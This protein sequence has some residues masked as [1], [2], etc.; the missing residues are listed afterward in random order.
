MPVIEGTTQHSVLARL[1]HH[2]AAHEPP[3]G[4]PAV[5]QQAAHRWRARTVEGDPEEQQA[6]VQQ[7]ALGCVPAPEENQQRVT[8]PASSGGSST[9]LTGL[10][11]RSANKGITNRKNHR[12]TSKLF[13]FSSS[14]HPAGHH[15]AN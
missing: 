13:H 3:H 10:L 15:N 5:G 14:P 6:Q 2:V 1:Q 11:I 7:A 8:R 4:P 9:A 12:K